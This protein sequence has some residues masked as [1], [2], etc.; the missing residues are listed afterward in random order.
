MDRDDDPLLAFG[1]SLIRPG[2]I[3]TVTQLDGKELVYR[4]VAVEAE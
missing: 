1:A 3:A 2:D 4:I